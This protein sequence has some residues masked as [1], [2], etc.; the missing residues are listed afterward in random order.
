[1]GSSQQTLEQALEQEEEVDIYKEPCV[2]QVVPATIHHADLLGR[3]IV[4]TFSLHLHAARC[5]PGGS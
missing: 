2:L 5:A 3:T 1:M 4:A